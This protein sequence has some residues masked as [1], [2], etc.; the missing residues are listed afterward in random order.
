MVSLL[1]SERCLFAY[2]HSGIQYNVTFASLTQARCS[3]CY[4]AKYPSRTA[5]ANVTSCAGPFLFVGMRSLGA[6]I[7]TFGAYAAASEVQKPSRLNSPHLSNGVY[8]YFKEGEYFGFLSSQNM[9]LTSDK[10]EGV[11]VINPNSTMLWS[12]SFPFSHLRSRALEINETS[13]DEKWIFSCPGNMLTSLRNVANGLMINSQFYLPCGTAG[14]H[15]APTSSTATAMGSTTASTYANSSFDI[16]AN[17]TTAL[18]QTNDPT[19]EPSNL[20]AASPKLPHLTTQ[21]GEWFVKI[22]KYIAYPNL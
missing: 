15:D 19:S 17:A 12:L 18:M 11:D 9:T 4:N 20:R 2:M 13:Y 16:V 7:F 10:R 21:K 14:S 5:S 6:A 8:W 22:E 3:M 1:L